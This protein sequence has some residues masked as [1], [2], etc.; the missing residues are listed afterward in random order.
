MDEVSAQGTPL[1]HFIDV[2]DGHE[3]PQYA[4]CAGSGE[5]CIG[6]DVKTY[7][8]PFVPILT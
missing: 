4:V 8:G 1:G 3:T 6:G 5:D 7:P 2:Y